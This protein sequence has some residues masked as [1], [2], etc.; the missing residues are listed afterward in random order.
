[1]ASQA[2][3]VLVADD[4][5]NA[6]FLLQYAFSTVAPHLPVV[7]TLDGRQALEYLL[8]RRASDPPGELPALMLLDLKMPQLSGFELLEIFAQ[9][10]NIRPA[11]V[12]VFSCSGQPED[13]SQADKLGANYYFVK[14]IALQE[15]LEVCREIVALCPPAQ[16]QSAEA[17]T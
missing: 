6:I 11:C 10:P 15:L 1:M 3:Y 5:P 4:D 14:P 9:N 13:R 12:A 16:P 7:Y 2:P 8:K 17:S